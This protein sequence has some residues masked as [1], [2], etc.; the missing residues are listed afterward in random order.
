MKNGQ[1]ESGTIKDRINVEVLKNNSD[2][3]DIIHQKFLQ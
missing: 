2:G 3:K 1:I